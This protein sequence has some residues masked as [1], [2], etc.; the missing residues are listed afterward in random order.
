[1][2]IARGVVAACCLMVAGTMCAAEAHAAAERTAARV[3]STRVLHLHFAPIGAGE[4]LSDGQ[5]TFLFPGFPGGGTVIDEGDGMESTVPPP[6]DC[7]SDLGPVIG[8]GEL[9]FD[10]DVSAGSAELYPLPQGPWR[11]I[12]INPVIPGECSAPGGF[13]CQFVA[14]GSQWA[15]FDF[16]C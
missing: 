4:V 14:V 10:C 8:S 7:S 2:R 9:L 3:R 6:P 15:Q 13:Q 5:F 11:S 12:A 16:Q 1:M